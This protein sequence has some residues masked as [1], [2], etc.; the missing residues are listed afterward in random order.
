MANKLATVNRFV[1]HVYIT[2][3]AA[4]TRITNIKINTLQDMRVLRAISPS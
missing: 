4:I 3:L 2:H 1:L